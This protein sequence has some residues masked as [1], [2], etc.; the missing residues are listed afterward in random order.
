[1]TV[2]NCVRCNRMFQSDGPGKLCARCLDTDEED[3]KVVREYVY[4][5]PN[6]SIPEVSESTGVAEE[7]ILKFL[8][9]GKLVLKDSTSMVLDCERC[10]KSITSG[11]YCESCTREMSRDLKS[12]ASQ[13]AQNIQQ[14]S[15]ANARGMFTKSEPGKK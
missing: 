2:K 4:D 1:M 6:C 14:K 7:K 5:N 15:G 3:F 13:T 10:G 8:R 12:A 9:Q 11:K